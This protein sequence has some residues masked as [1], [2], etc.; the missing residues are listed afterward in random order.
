M[1][2]MKGCQRTSNK[3]FDRWTHDFGDWEPVENGVLRRARDGVPFDEPPLGTYVISARTCKCCGHV[4][5]KQDNRFSRRS[6]LN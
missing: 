4:E 3:V 1:V 2:Y 5:E 6:A